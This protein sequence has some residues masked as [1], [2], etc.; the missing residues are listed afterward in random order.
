MT[1]HRQHQHGRM[2]LQH[3][4]TYT[5]NNS[6]IGVTALVHLYQ[7]DSGVHTNTREL[8]PHQCQFTELSTRAPNPPQ[9]RSSRRSHWYETCVDINTNCNTP[10]YGRVFDI[11]NWQL[12]YCQEQH[13]LALH[14][15]VSVGLCS[16]QA[17]SSHHQLL[18]GFASDCDLFPQRNISKYW[19]GNDVYILPTENEFWIIFQPRLF[20]WNLKFLKHSCDKIWIY[21]P[22]SYSVPCQTC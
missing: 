17:S 14:Q 2:V 21:A 8:Q 10:F 22:L 12:C 1:W 16:R 18:F 15:T 6:W 11:S 20:F 9:R 4:W 13:L 5:W 3:W 7:I 19:D